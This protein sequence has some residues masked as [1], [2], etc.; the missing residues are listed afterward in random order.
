MNEK[1]KE[2]DL[3]D[4]IANGLPFEVR[5]EF[6]NEMRHLHSLPENDEMLRILRIMQFLTLLTEQVPMRVLTERE[7][8]EIAC[9]EI[10]TTAQKLEKT[11]S[12]YYRQLDQRLIKLPDDIAA[13][14][15]PI[16][17]VALINSLLKKQFE[18]TTIPT[19][20]NKL[21]ANAEI[22]NNATK[23]YAQ[24]NKKLCDSWQATA[25][26]AH[27]TIG[28]IK[29]A[30]SG[31]AEASQKAAVDFSKIFKKTYRKTLLIL[32][33]IMLGTGIM[34]G[35]VVSDYFRP[36]MKTVYEI[37][38]DIQLLIEQKRERDLLFARPE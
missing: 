35:I 32:G 10:I 29:S 13:R 9:S 34:I 15:N 38:P 8:L 28:K 6:L 12:E 27:E 23:E 22:I 36:R 25:N 5:A 4:K 17:I 24:A 11:G 2:P 20:A 3:I 26:K 14:L 31:A 1:T 19:V 7:K 33:A 37:P 16:S 21:A 18:A 30:V